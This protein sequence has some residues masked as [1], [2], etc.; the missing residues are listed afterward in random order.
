QS[1]YNVDNW[2]KEVDQQAKPNIQIIVLANKY[3]LVEQ[4]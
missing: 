4:S 1:F 3:D 2:L